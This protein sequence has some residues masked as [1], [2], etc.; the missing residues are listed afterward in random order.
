MEGKC[1]MMPVKG[2][3]LVLLV[4]VF[5]IITPHS[6][7]QQS[8]GLVDIG[9]HK[10]NYI[11]MG[12][13]SPSVVIDVGFGESYNS[14]MT[15]AETISA[16]T[17]VVMFDRAGYGQSEP[18]PFPRTC[19]QESIELKALLDSAAI[20]PPYILVGHSLGGLNAQYFAGQY[21]E[22]VE[23][24]I[25]LDPPPLEWIAGKGFPELRKMAEDQTSGMQTAY[26][27]MLKSDNPDDRKKGEFIKTL[28][29]EHNEMFGTSARLVSEIK[30][31][32][33]ILVTVI[34]SGKPN[35]H[36]GMDAEAFQKFWNEQCG[37]IADKS[38]N[39]KYILIIKSSHHIHKDAPEKVIAEINNLIPKN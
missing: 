15:I 5:T 8:G 9:T 28:Y 22:L 23:G 26:Q 2:K 35:E 4:T 1:K 3:L 21:P 29:S 27:S 11:S 38:E 13:G 25:L 16:M 18:G 14:W 17:R 36:F 34:A 24:M 6:F 10:L 7:C 20:A 31:F 33:S 37:L 12:S 32:G 30:S 39:G 19:R